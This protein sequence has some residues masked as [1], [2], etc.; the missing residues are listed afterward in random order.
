[1]NEISKKK[2]FFPICEDLQKYLEL[3]ERATK[4]PIKYED[5]S[6]SVG[7][8]PL[9]DKEGE[10]TLWVS[11]M[12]AQQDI[13]ELNDGLTMIYAI[14]KAGGAIDLMEHLYVDRIDYCTFGNSKPYR[15]RIKNKLNDNYDYYYIKKG[16]ASRIYGLELED[17]MSPNRINYLIDGDTLI[18]EHIAGIPGDVFM[19]KYVKTGEVNKV[20]LA[21]EFIKFNERCFMRLLGDMRAY[22][23]VLDITPD[24]DEIQ[25][26]IRAIDFDQQSF[27]GKKNIYRPQF[28]KENKPLV[29]LVTDLLDEKTIKQYQKEER[30][31]VGRRLKISRYRIKNLL[32]IM[33]KDKVSNPKKV[34]QLSAELNKHFGNDKFSHCKTMGELI[35]ANLKMSIRSI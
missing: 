9:Y 31:L 4:L 8:I 5:L 21:K 14:L 22:N 32:D 16:D 27:E 29:D 19:E 20:R 11:M 6:R 10:D 13:S 30:T 33:C 2:P 12:Y 23:Y 18:E 34:K 17:L 1:M 24:F 25:Y 15:I 26:R 28:F 7:N 35:K 3:Y